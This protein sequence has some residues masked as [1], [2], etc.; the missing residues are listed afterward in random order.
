MSRLDSPC[1]L[2]S[3]G[4][5][6]RNLLDLVERAELALGR[7]SSAEPRL[8]QPWP[9]LYRADFELW[10]ARDSRADLAEIAA[11]LRYLREFTLKPVELGAPGPAE[12]VGVVRPA[13]P[14]VALE[15]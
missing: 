13:L 6:E 8:G 11:V 15:H 4:H 3:R 2:G 7:L 14:V 9:P 12:R 1:L 5:R 10:A